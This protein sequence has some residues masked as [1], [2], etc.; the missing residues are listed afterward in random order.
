MSGFL[1]GAPLTPGMTTPDIGVP[2]CHFPIAGQAPT[3]PRRLRVLVRLDWLNPSSPHDGSG[4]FMIQAPG[5]G[6]VIPGRS[7][8]ASRTTAG[9]AVSD[10][11][12]RTW[13]GPLAERVPRQ[14]AERVP[15]QPVGVVTPQTSARR[16]RRGPRFAQARQPLARTSPARGDRHRATWRQL[17]A[18]GDGFL[19]FD[20]RRQVPDLGQRQPGKEHV[21]GTTY[22]EAAI[23][24][25]RSA[26]HPLTARE[27]TARAIETGLITTTGKTPNATMS[28]ALTSKSTKTPLS[29]RSRSLV[30]DARSEAPC[31][32][33]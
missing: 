13:S 9:S 20:S 7:R 15:R 8:H 32:R 28:A 31:V 17:P 5:H 19:D 2:R 3:P 29:P 6:I 11:R 14:L 27:I 23:Q 1:P 21:M 18:D 22:Y 24:V 10:V 25:L 30:T 12:A 33:C 16:R 26:Q 4:G